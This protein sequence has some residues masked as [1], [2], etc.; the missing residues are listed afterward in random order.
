MF[1]I[2]LV[3]FML[4]LA[5]PFSI[6]LI[7][8]EIEDRKTTDSIHNKHMKLLHRKYFDKANFTND[9]KQLLIILNSRAI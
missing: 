7:Y 4:I 8:L 3:I 6:I 1:N 2:I 5:V 9:D